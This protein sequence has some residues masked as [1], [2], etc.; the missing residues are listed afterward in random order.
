MI[1]IYYIEYLKGGVKM[2]V[3]GMLYLEQDGFI[4]V[5]CSGVKNRQPNT[6]PTYKI[7]SKSSITK[8][9][10]IYIVESLTSSK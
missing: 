9:I 10:P 1:L 7:I 4:A 2:A 8:K 5:V 6:L 3:A